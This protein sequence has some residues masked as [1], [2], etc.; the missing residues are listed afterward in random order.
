MTQLQS[1]LDNVDVTG[2]LGSGPAS[3]VVL[4]F[5]SLLVV[6]IKAVA[7]DFGSTQSGM[8]TTTIGSNA[9]L[10]S[11]ISESDDLTASPFSSGIGAAAKRVIGKVFA[12]SRHPSTVQLLSIDEAGG[13]TWTSIWAAAEAAGVSF[14]GVLVVS[15]QVADIADVAGGV[16]ALQGDYLVFAGLDDVSVAAAANATWVAN[17]IGTLS[18][19]EKQILWVSFHDDNMDA[20]TDA[21]FA[22]YAAKYLTADFDTQCAGANMVMGTVSSMAALTGTQKTNLDAN[23]VNHALP[24]YSAT[25]YM[26]PG[27]MQSG[28]PIYDVTTLHWMRNRIRNAL[29][30]VKIAHVE[31]GLKIPMDSS[32]Q[33]LGVNA[34][35][36]VISKGLQAGHFMSE[37]EATGQGKAAPYVKALAISDPST[38]RLS[39]EVLQYSLQDA[40]EFK[41]TFFL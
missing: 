16:A 9:S 39:F 21:D 36:G 7:G 30:A 24:F 26:D 11:T 27:N 10:L 38:R 13:D 3:G 32:G 18:A 12:A 40:R 28:N 14:Y 17:D 22:E 25:A 20:G 35:E 6:D 29:A 5:S 19:A 37:A 23:N 31:R 33:R 4:D 8:T 1:H 2:S 34:I 41:V 15:D